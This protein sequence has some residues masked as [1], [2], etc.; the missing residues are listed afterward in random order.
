MMQK[1]WKK[2]L[3]IIGLLLF[4]IALIACINDRIPNVNINET[5]VPLVSGEDVVS[6]KDFGAY[7]DGIH[8]DAAAIQKALNSGYHKIYFPSG[9]Y[10][11]NSFIVMK[12]PNVKVTGKKSVIFTDNDYSG[13]YHEWFFSIVADDIEIENMKFESR[14]T[15]KPKFKTQVGVMYA[16]RVSFKKCEFNIPESVLSDAE[17]RKVEYTNLDIYTD[18][19]DILV[20]ECVFHDLADA[21]AGGCV[22]IRDIKGYRC[23]GMTFQKNVLYQNGRD[24]I[25]G[26]FSNIS[27]KSKTN[28][29]ENVV[30]DENKFYQEVGDNYTRHVGLSLGYDG[31]KGA[32]NVTF[33]NNYYSGYADYEF[34]KLGGSKDV[35]VENNTLIVNLEDTNAPLY[36]FR[37]QTKDQSI[38][39]KNNS[40]DVKKNSLGDFA[41]IGRG[42]V[43]YLNNDIVC[44]VNCSDY[45]FSYLS[46]VN[47]NKVTVSGKLKKKFFSPEVISKEE[48]EIC[49]N[50]RKMK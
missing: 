15:I 4:L 10:K 1:A 48:N 47:N 8:D 29:L 22:E 44:D 33:S 46:Y 17:D 45:V 32:D 3:Q 11:C 12:T 25:L 13:K 26:V 41:G 9:E 28:M 5:E 21:L 31:N 18:W 50:D 20:E 16:D 6:V 49:L 35:V 40:I 42:Y 2:Y 14:E 37:A 43:Y 24:E 23:S 19:H 34:L 38:Y 39:V 7:G 36:L 30:I 27:Q